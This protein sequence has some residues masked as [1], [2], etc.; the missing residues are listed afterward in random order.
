MTG[1]DQAKTCRNLPGS[2]RLGM[3]VAQTGDVI[4][5]VPGHPMVAKPRS[6]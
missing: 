2:G 3:G 4:Y 1:F 5:A 6:Q